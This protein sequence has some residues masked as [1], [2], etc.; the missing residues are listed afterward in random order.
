MGLQLRL[1]ASVFPWDKPVLRYASKVLYMYFPFASDRFKS[2]DLI[3]W[4]ALLAHQRHSKGRV[5]RFYLWV[6]GRED[7]SD[8]SYRWLHCLGSCQSASGF[9]H[10]C[11]CVTR[12]K[13]NSENGRCHLLIIMNGF[14]L[15]DPL[16][17][18]QEPPGVHRPSI[19]Q[20]PGEVFA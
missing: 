11:L 6:C 15:T 20:I 13:A 8:S 17:A 1:P 14:D 7:Y 9:I 16:N 10:P 4:L 3:K 12:G 19:M 5:A 18:S 2:Q